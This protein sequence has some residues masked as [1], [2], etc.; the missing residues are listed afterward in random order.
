[1]IRVYDKGEKVIK[2]HKHAGDSKRGKELTARF[3]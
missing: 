3:E 2:T 1:M